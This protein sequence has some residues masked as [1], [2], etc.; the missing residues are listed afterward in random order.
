MGV[1][2]QMENIRVMIV[3]DGDAIRD[4][5]RIYMRN[6]GYEVAAAKD[7]QEALEIL[8][9]YAVQLII[10]DLMM[11]RMDGVSFCMKLRE[12]SQVPIIMLSAK[13]EDMD[14]IHGLSIGADDYMTKPFNPMELLA[15]VK[16]QLRRYLRYQPQDELKNDILDLRGLKLNRTTHQVWLQEQEIRLTPKEFAILELLMEHTGMV[17]SAERIYMA[18]WQEAFMESENTVMVHIRNI[19]EKIE[20]DPRKPTYLKNVWG[21]GYKID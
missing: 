5:I 15:R 7:G 4:V 12:K 21:V 14:K 2:M 8:E 17:F 11:P 6:A 13:T 16:S 3:D 1:I 20:K 18:V 9:K 19:R 10:L